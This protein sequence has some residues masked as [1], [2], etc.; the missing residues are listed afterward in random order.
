MQNLIFRKGFMATVLF[1]TRLAASGWLNPFNCLHDWQTDVATRSI[2]PPHPHSFLMYMRTFAKKYGLLILC[3]SLCLQQEEELQFWISATHSLLWL[4]SVIY[5]RQPKHREGERHWGREGPFVAGRWRKFPVFEVSHRPL[6]RQVL[7]TQES[8]CAADGS[9]E[10]TSLPPVASHMG[11]CIWK[12]FR[13]FF[14]PED[15]ICCLKIYHT[16][17]RH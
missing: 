8:S 4:L 1:Q 17:M 9:N 10:T 5:E 12:S 6:S 3:C 14:L 16:H 7:K 11:K 15:F 13:F 2:L